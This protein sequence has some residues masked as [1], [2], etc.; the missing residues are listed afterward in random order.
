MTSPRAA[1]FVP[2]LLLSACA[3]AQVSGNG[4]ARE[5]TRE[6]A[7]FTGV[8]VGS[9]L[10]AK[11]TVGPKSVR[12]SGDENL[13]ALV[14][15][16]VDDGKLEVR[17]EKG[18]RVK[19]T[20][21]LRITISSPQVTSVGASGGAVVEAEASASSNFAAAASGGG[22]VDVRNVDAKALAVDASGGAV[23]KVKGRTDALAVEASG[24]SEV[25]A[26][27]LS[28]KTLAV[29]ASGG[30]AVK[31]NPSESIAAELS[32]GSTVHV[33]SSPARRAVST[34]GGSEVIFS[35]K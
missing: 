16:E 4:V 28:V 21:K 33:D 35:R 19:G 22:E 6:V 29:D 14:R 9:G 15:T 8:E 32:G 27:E 18:S 34:S 3:F 20:S 13:V 12:I 7:D 31:A 1:L 11:V 26:Q 10:N 2:A 17:L 25:H 23:V 30:C 5:E 24:G